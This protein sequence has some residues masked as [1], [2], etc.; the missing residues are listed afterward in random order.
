MTDQTQ[1]SAASLLTERAYDDLLRWVIVV[2]LISFGAVILW[3]YG[4][5]NYLISN[6]TTY[7]TQLILVVFVLSSV[8]VLWHL[9]V[10]SAELRATSRVLAQLDGPDAVVALGTVP[11]PGA[12]RVTGFVSDVIRARQL[13]P[14]NAADML[15]QSVGAD[16]RV[17]VRTGIYLVDALY[18][19]GML[20]AVVGFILMLSSIRDLSTFDA[21]SLRTAMQ[22][23]TAGMAISLLTTIAGL[24]T[25]MLLR[26]QTNILDSLALKVLRR[27]VRLN[28]VQLPAL[29]AGR[30][31]V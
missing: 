2:I 16:L 7:I 29:L 4:F 22:R 15:L 24:A 18:K 10:L 26:L 20:G 21:E 8:F 11:G 27:L 19:L 14:E 31:H 25:G 6:D 5:L 9:L 23:M 12:A 30:P 3:D 28:Q 17:S 1:G 13:G